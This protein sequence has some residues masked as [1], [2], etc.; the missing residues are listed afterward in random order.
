MRIACFSEHGLTY[1]RFEELGIGPILF[2]EEAIFKREIRFEDPI[3]VDVQ[4]TRATRDFAGWSLCHRLY[5]ADES[6][7]AVINLD[8][9]WIDL[10]IRKLTIPNKDVQSIFAGFPRDGSFGWEE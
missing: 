1:K 10:R 9:A 2:R 3:A 6:L 7:C 5:K 4:V 8:G